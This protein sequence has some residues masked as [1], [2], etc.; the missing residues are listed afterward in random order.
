MITFVSA[1][2]E[3]LQILPK[4]TVLLFKFKWRIQKNPNISKCH[5]AIED[6]GKQSFFSG[7]ALFSLLAI[8]ADKIITIRNIPI[9]P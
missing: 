1:L 6:I 2:Y 5:P 3:I 4:K 9:L 7:F 8:H